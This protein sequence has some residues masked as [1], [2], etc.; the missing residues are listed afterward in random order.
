M[1]KENNTNKSILILVRLILSYIKYFFLTWLVGLLLGTIIFITLNLNP[2]ISFGFFRY[3][4]FINPLYAGST[5]NMNLTGIMQ[6]FSVVSLVLM[7]TT[8]LIK[9]ILNKLFKINFMGGICPKE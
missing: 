2:N 9:I 7:I 4:S 8:T 5:F 1:I 3:F 6:I